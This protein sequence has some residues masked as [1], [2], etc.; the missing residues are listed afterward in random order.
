MAN[1]AA[2]D[3]EGMTLYRAGRFEDAAAR[4]AEAQAAFG[5]AGNLK[6][7]AE[8]ANNQGMAWRQAAR[9][10]EA[11]AAFQEARRMFQSLANGSGEG[12]VVGNLAALADSAGD[13]GQAAAYYSEAIGLLESAGEHDLAQ[14]TYT[15][16][17]RLKLKHGDWLG[18]IH[19]FEVGL[20]QLEHPTVAQRL[21]R[22]LLDTP[23][24]LTGG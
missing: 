4:F 21:A 22:K 13:A 15:A 2:F 14:T 6:A 12:Q 9:W 5:A 7:A 10:N 20:A 1:G 17:S 8:A 24:K 18:A 16:L 11:A 3:A 23:R 19:A